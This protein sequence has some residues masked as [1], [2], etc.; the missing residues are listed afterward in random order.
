MKAPE[1]EDPWLRTGQVGW[2]THRERLAGRKA[3]RLGR[4]YSGKSHGEEI[5][6]QSV[7]KV[8][9]VLS[10]LLMNRLGV[11]CLKTESLPNK[12]GLSNV[13]SVAMR[14]FALDQAL[15]WSLG[16]SCD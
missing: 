7:I 1:R 11:Q 16:W 10:K 12:S 3:G 13:P 6:L 8:P 5:N 15:C 4:D 9:S 14:L 2:N